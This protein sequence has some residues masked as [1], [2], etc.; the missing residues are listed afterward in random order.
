ML[1][2][3][4]LSSALLLLCLGGV[5]VRHIGAAERVK[6]QTPSVRKMLDTLEQIDKAT[7]L[8]PDKA[9]EIFGAKLKPSANSGNTHLHTFVGETD[10]WKQIELRFPAGGDGSKFVLVLEPATP[11]PMK[12]VQARFGKET[13]MEPPSPSMPKDKALIG[14]V[15]NRPVGKLRFAFPSFQDFNARVVLVDRM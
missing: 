7:A 6:A 8:S 1:T 14:Y 12:D 15:Y 13:A 4:V 11:L 3:V 9:R 10:E 5:P 2:R